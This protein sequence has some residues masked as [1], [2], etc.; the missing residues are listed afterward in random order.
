MELNMLTEDFGDESLGGDGEVVE[1]V[2]EEVLPR[3][4]GQ[5]GQG[6]RHRAE[7]SQPRQT[8]TGKQKLQRN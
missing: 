8:A 6:R 1:R 4:G 2:L 3:D 7:I 5:R